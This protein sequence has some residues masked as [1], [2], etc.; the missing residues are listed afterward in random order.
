MATLP[1]Q[2]MSSRTRQPLLRTADTDKFLASFKEAW[3]TRN[4]ELAASLF[5]RDA[6]YRKD[7]FDAP[8][9]GREAIHDYW[10]LA[11]SVQ[12]DVHFTVTNAFRSGYVLVAEWICTYCQRENGHRREL[13]GMFVADFYGKQVRN[14]RAYWHSRII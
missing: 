14:F 5:T 4:A 13:A 7:P 11:T 3:E 1:K 8:I 2:K 10:H 6:Y 12:K 9:V